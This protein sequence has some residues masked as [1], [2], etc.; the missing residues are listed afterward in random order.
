[1]SLHGLMQDEPLLISSF[2]RYAAEYHGDREI[3]ARSCEGPIVRSNYAQVEKRAR[4]LGQALI[5]LGVKPGDRIATLAWNTVRHFECFYGVSGIGAVLHTVNPRLFE[6]QIQYI[7][8]HAEDQYLF[9]DL[10]FLPLVERI[11][12]QITCVKGFVFLC[13]KEDLPSSSSLKNVMSYEEIVGAQSGEF[14]W[15]EFDERAASSL[16]YTSGTTGNPKGVLYGHR[17]TVLHALG[18]NQPGVFGITSA[19]TAL[20]VVPMYHANAWSLPYVVPM[21][22]AKF[23]LIGPKHDPESVHDLIEQEQVTFACAVPTVWTM[24]VDYL[25]SSG[26][27]LDS[28]KKCMIGGTALP[29]VI[30]D[31]YRDDYGVDVMQVWGM[32]ETSPLGTIGTATPKVD[33]MPKDERDEQLLKQGRIPYGVQIKITDGDGTRVPRNGEDFGAI[34]I[35]GPWIAKGYFKGEGG[36]ML[37]ED[38]W[39]PTGDVGTLDELGYMKITDRTKDVIKSGG[40][41]ISSID[42]EN[43]AMSHPK[44]QLAAAIAAY[45]PKWDERPLLVVVAADS[46]KPTK[47]EMLEHLEGRIAKWWMPDDVIVID[48]MPL[49]ATGKILK[50]NLRERFWEHLNKPE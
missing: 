9:L 32:T 28:M 38:G 24:M 47:D 35:K 26:K 18:A 1:M 23:V 30:R 21:T 13:S 10:E 19:D 7:I 46:D 37:D 25:R 22:G 8:S 33:A 11:A 14:A 5:E 49:T 2:I 43:I 27:N 16:C 17:S 41:W 3:V 50:A 6:T 12:G 15:P 29:K 44:V 48:E 4:Q 45:H 39:F 31:T 40:E 20:A 42:L 36:T 34:W